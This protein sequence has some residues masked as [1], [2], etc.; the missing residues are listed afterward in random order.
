MMDNWTVGI[1]VHWLFHGRN[2]SGKIEY[3]FVREALPSREEMDE[4]D[5]MFFLGRFHA[6]EGYRVAV[7]KVEAD[8]AA[9]ERVGQYQ[10]W[11]YRDLDAKDWD[12]KYLWDRAAPDA[13]EPVAWAFADEV[14]CGGL[15][16][17]GRFDVSG[18]A[19]DFRKLWDINA[20]VTSDSDVVEDQV[21]VLPHTL[22]TKCDQPLGAVI[23]E[24]AWQTGQHIYEMRFAVKFLGAGEGGHC[25]CFYVECPRCGTDI[26]MVP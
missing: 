17:Y 18:E 15:W 4:H 26:K 24:V 6:K 2:Y 1:P 22:C 9:S 5:M 7:S 16:N 3:S 14:V 23:K 10:L 19:L 20:T 21:W 8:E 11:L 25:G 12:D 13:R